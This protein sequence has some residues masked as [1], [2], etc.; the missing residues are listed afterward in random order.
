MH[1][2]WSRWSYRWCSQL[3]HHSYRPTLA[4]RPPLLPKEQYQNVHSLECKGRRG[5]LPIAWFSVPRLHKVRSSLLLGFLK[6]MLP[7]CRG[8]IH[9]WTR[10]WSL[11]CFIYR[12]MLAH[13]LSSFKCS[14]FSLIRSS[15]PPAK[16]SLDAFFSSDSFV[17]RNKA[18]A[19]SAKLRFFFLSKRLMERK[20]LLMWISDDYLS[21]TKVFASS[22]HENAMYSRSSCFERH[23]VLWRHGWSVQS[24]SLFQGRRAL[25]NKMRKH[26]RKNIALYNLSTNGRIQYCRMQTGAV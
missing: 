23:F 19:C 5:I 21:I 14:T 4:C 17:V 22:G 18:Y 24:R 13:L 8:S 6:C 11:A 10:G 25:W 9:A 20:D 3:D 15:N 26:L 16:T 7:F 1:R 12:K 2:K